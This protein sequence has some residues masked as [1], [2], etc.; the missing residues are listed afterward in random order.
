MGLNKD[1]SIKAATAGKGS[2][3]VILDGTHYETKVFNTIDSPC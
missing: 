1:K 2:E 3:R